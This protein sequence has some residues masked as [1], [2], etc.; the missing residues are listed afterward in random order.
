MCTTCSVFTSGKSA[1]SN[2]HNTTDSVGVTTAR[3]Q[4]SILFSFSHEQCPQQITPDHLSKMFVDI[5]LHTKHSC[6]DTQRRQTQQLHEEKRSTDVRFRR[7]KRQH[8]VPSLLLT[9]LL[10]RDHSAR[11]ATSPNSVSLRPDNSLSDAETYGAVGSLSR[12]ARRP[13]LCNE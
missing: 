2:T 3:R 5:Q 8:A 9:T 7:S 4:V 1:S 6:D 11:R 10:S 12:L 13:R